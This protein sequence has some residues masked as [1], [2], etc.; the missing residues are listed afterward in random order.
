M[1]H[2]LGAARTL[3]AKRVRSRAASIVK[4]PPKRERTPANRIEGQS[5]GFKCMVFL[6]SMGRFRRRGNPRSGIG[7]VRMRAGTSLYIALRI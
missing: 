3:G 4:Y 5:G 2:A 7:I 6:S 1:L